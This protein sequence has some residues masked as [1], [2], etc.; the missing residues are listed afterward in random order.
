MLLKDT[1]QC[2]DRNSSSS[3]TLTVKLLQ[4]QQYYRLRNCFCYSNVKTVFSLIVGSKFNNYEYKS[5]TEVISDMQLM[6]ENCY[7][8]N[9][10][11]HWVSKQGQK[12]EKVLEQKCAL[13][14]RSLILT[15]T[16]S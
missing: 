1:L 3:H 14:N 10:A 16:V 5:I 8:Y 15:F 6:L 13:L 11:D 4:H 7:R 12:L 2:S 9:G